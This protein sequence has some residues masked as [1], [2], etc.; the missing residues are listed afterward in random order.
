MHEQLSPT[1][2]ADEIEAAILAA[3][4]L[5]A[6]IR[7]Y[8]AHRV[9]PNG[10]ARQL[11]Y[12]ADETSLRAGIWSLILALITHRIYEDYHVSTVEIIAVYPIH[13]HSIALH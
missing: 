9:E 8:I 4:S 1:R 11:L 12:P 10:V 6:H 13:Y 2:R 7:D 3:T 5:T